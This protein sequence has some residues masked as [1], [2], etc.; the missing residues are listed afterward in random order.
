[1][2]PP[3]DVT[4]SLRPER[5]ELLELLGGLDDSEW[6]APTECPAWTVKGVALHVLG[7]D[8]SL[9]SRQRDEAVQGLILYAE[10]RPGLNFRQLLDGFNEQWVEAARFLSPPLLIELLRLAGE[11]TAAFYTEVD[12]QRPGE[13]V[14]FFGARGTMSSSAT[15]PASPYWQA[16]AREYVERWVHQHQIRR[17]LGCP[18]LGREFLEPAVATITRSF[19]AHLPDLG[20]EAGTIVR[21]SVDDVGTWSLTLAEDGWSFADGAAA[22]PAVELSLSQAD[23]TPVLSRNR[24]SADAVA[25]FRVSGDAALVG[26]ALEVVGLMV[27]SNQ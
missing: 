18:D 11:W 4:A 25:A 16:I 19:A 26:R 22:D 1:M 24:S 10:T 12:P 6:N 13:P 27:D 7:D 5:D 17:A 2:I 8:L 21:F 9:V 23:A 15:S 14:G 3:L 20:A